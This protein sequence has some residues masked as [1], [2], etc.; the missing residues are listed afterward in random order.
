MNQHASRMISRATVTSLFI[1]RL[2]MMLRGTLP[3]RLKKNSA[4]QVPPSIR[5]TLLFGSPGDINRPVLRHACE[6]CD[7]IPLLPWLNLLELIIA[8]HGSLGYGISVAHITTIGFLSN[9]GIYLQRLWR[10]GFAQHA[11][12]DKKPS[13]VPTV[14][15]SVN[16]H[17]LANQWLS[18]TYRAEQFI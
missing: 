12:Q 17:S 11:D 3:S 2:G 7:P 9:V 8:Y 13:P 6:V 4:E 10:T 5:F 15:S 18:I 1:C 14:V 16:N